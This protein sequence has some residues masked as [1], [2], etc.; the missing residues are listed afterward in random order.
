M[1]RSTDIV[2]KQMAA[3]AMEVAGE[4]FAAQADQFADTIPPGIT[5]AEALRG[6]A[7]AI[8]STRAKLGGANLEFKQ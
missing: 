3:M 6:F 8:R 5:A 2:M 1:T 4:F 7:R